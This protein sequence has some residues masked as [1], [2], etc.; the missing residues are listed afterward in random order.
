M[1]DLTPGTWTIDPSHSE[2]A[3]TVRH[4]MSKVR[5]T[6]GEFS[7]TITTGSADPADAAVEA[8]VKVASIDTRDAKRDAH[9]R[10]SEILG[11]DEFPT[12]SFRSTKVTGDA[13]G[14]QIH[15][16]LTIKDVTKPVVFDAEFQGVINPDPFGLVRMG[17]EGTTT[18][19]KKEFGVDFN[20]PLQGDAVML[21][22]KIKIEVSLE[23]TL[24]Q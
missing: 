17:A 24:N 6:F 21:G 1:T 16:D 4:L 3:F 14:Y 19:S 23:A 2:V 9:I 10:T 12:F 20:I 13:D 18:I 7:G 11:A 22:D 8:D 15:G 5:G